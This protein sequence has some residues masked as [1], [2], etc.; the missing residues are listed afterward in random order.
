M[1]MFCFQCEQTVAG[2]GCTVRGV[3]GKDE[4]TANN[5]DGLT[6]ELVNLAAAAEKAKKFEESSV[7]FLLDGLF[8][9]ITN[10]NFDPAAAESLRESAAAKR[11]SLGG[12]EI[13]TAKDLWSGDKDIRS[14]RSTL[15]FGLDGMAAYA[16]HARVLGKID[17]DVDAWMYKGLAALAKEHS[18]DEWLGLLMELGQVNLKCMALLDEAN[19]SA[20]GMPVPVKVSTDIEKGPFIVISGHDLKDLEMLLKQTQG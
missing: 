2:K 10:V 6:A 7:K 17:K 15:L 18:V 13:F 12:D 20:Y 5:L 3:C 4:V 16:H 14:L 11:K 19:T 9:R 8:M 1:S